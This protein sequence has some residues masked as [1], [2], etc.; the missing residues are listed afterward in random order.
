VKN[1]TKKGDFCKN[2]KLL[3]VSKADSV[4]TIDVWLCM[5]DVSLQR[6]VDESDPGRDN[7][8]K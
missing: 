1:N 5:N 8:W 6:Y 2:M 3:I 4:L 7:A